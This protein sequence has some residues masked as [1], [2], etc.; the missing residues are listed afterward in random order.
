VR[1]PRLFPCVRGRRSSDNLVG[2]AM[3]DAYTE[4]CQAYVGR[5]ITEGFGWPDRELHVDRVFQKHPDLYAVAGGEPSE[6]SSLFRRGTIW[7]GRNRVSRRGALL[8]LARWTP[9]DD[10][11]H[12]IRV[13]RVAA[14]KRVVPRPAAPAQ[15]APQDGTRDCMNWGCLRDRRDRAIVHADGCPNRCASSALEEHPHPR[16]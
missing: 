2:V 6:R 3:R 11:Q 7:A 14:A 15:E 13:K 4:M 16:D 12:R 8:A 9:E 10:A 5:R 1:A